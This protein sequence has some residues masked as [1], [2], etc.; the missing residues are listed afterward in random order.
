[1]VKNGCEQLESFRDQSLYR[2][3]KILV[4]MLISQADGQISSVLKLTV[5]V[6]HTS[7]FKRERINLTDDCNQSAIPHS[8]DSV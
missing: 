3:R 8:D 6:D 5:H 2:T 7:S 1:M 4:C